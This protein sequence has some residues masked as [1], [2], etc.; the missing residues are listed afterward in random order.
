MPRSQ[1][2]ATPGPFDDCIEVQKGSS[3]IVIYSPL[4]QQVVTI[5]WCVFI[6]LPSC[7]VAYDWF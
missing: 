1:A 3:D 6:F 4:A 2:R 5:A 7:D